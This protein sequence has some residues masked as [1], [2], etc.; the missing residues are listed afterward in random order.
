MRSRTILLAIGI[1][2]LLVVPAVA[3]V[4]SI[5][6]N[7]KAVPLHNIWS[8]RGNGIGNA[9]AGLWDINGDGRSEFAVQESNGGTWSVISLDSAGH[10][11]ELWR[12]AFGSPQEIF[13]G[14]LFGNGRPVLIGDR[15]VDTAYLGTLYWLE[16]F[17][18]DSGRIADTPFATWHSRQPGVHLA[19]TRFY[20][21]DLDSD[22]ADELI[23]TSPVTNRNDTIRRY[24]EIWIYRGGPNFTIDTPTVVIRDSEDHGSNFHL[25][26][27]RLDRDQYPDLIVVTSDGGRIRWGGPDITLLD[28]PVDRQPH[29]PIPIP[30]THVHLLDADGDGYSD[31]LWSGSEALLH[32]SSTS[33]FPR[34]REYSRTDVDRV[35][36]GRGTRT[37]VLGPLND[38]SG[39]YDMFGLSTGMGDA[40]DLIF[41]GG[42]GGP[43]AAYDAWYNTS[44]DGLGSGYA[45]Y[46][47][48]PAGDVDGNGWNDW[49]I[50][51]ERFAGGGG[52][53]IVIGGG[54]YIP[55]DSMPASSIRDIAI[56]DRARALTVWPNPVVDVV[57]IA[58]RGDLSMTP[59]SFDAYDVL[60][61]LVARGD[62]DHMRGE[63][64]WDLSSL[65]TGI[66]FLSVKDRAG[67][68]IATTS[69]RKR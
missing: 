19:G 45:T 33:K 44:G 41:S 23:I 36:V 6:A 54:P 51:T 42:A 21:G 18:V 62:A 65:P 55:R 15:Q 16:F 12:H 9:V 24:G 25:S 8:Q 48:T 60:G 38:S 2:T 7:P 59:E 61:R 26:I 20:V 49:L 43:D 11:H 37:F 39:R 28:R 17:G 53:A 4:D 1:I 57:H 67:A 64:V 29:F 34:S 58:W 47:H 46:N 63:V 56:G 66:Y 3:Q 68:V 5:R 31:L 35:F 27:G 32:L 10:P 69:I 13:F 40:T 14:D 30:G 50:G 52:I 22:G